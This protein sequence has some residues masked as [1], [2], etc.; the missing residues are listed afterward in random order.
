MRFRTKIFLASLAV[1]ALSLMVAWPL[2]VESGRRRQAQHQQTALAARAKGIAEYLP[3]AGADSGNLDAIADRL[4]HVVGSRITFVDAAG[5]VLGDSGI[6]TA[7]LA[8]S[9]SH[10][11]RPEIADARLHGVGQATRYSTTLGRDLHYV[12]I[13]ANVGPVAFIRLAEPVEA[14]STELGT[15]ARQVAPVML[16]ALASAAFLAWLA[17][18]AMTRRFEH[19]AG[20]VARYARNDFSARTRDSSSDELGLISRAFDAAVD[21]QRS[22]LDDLSRDRARMGAILTGMIPPKRRSWRSPTTRPRP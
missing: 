6:D 8:A 11:A 9:E 14:T 4:A 21:S 3:R 20:V 15:L 13:R 16:T 10:A 18:R 2:L 1:S 7:D 12:A 17:S 22:R 5:R 19:L